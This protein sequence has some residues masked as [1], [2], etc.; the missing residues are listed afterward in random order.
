[1]TVHLR[2]S[3]GYLC[4]GTPWL[5][6]ECMQSLNTL[7]VKYKFSLK[8]KKQKLIISRM[9][10]TLHFHTWIACNKIMVSIIDTIITYL[11]EDQMVSTVVKHYHIPWYQWYLTLSTNYRLT[12]IYWQESKNILWKTCYI[13]ILFYLDICKI[14]W[15]LV[16]F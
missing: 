1:M 14:L 4:R 16:L 10:K 8:Y 5:L 15:S 2:N 12:L 6:S 9:V 13:H 7:R 11:S 3:H